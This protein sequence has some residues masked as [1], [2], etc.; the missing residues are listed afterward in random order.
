MRAPVG[1]VVDAE[2]DLA[3]K[4]TLDSDIPLVDVGVASRGRAEIVR[5][6]ISPVRKLAVLRALRTGKASRE[7]ILKGCGLGGELGGE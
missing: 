1:G 7:W 2:H 4:Q 3:G 5:V 6:L